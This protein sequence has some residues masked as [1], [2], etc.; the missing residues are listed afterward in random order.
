MNQLTHPMLV[1]RANRRRLGAASVT[2]LIASLAG[3]LLVGSAGPAQAAAVAVPLG[4]AHTFV[5]LAG[6]GTTNTGVTRLGG[7]IGTSPTPAMTGM[8]TAPADADRVVFT[9][10]GVNHA[11][12]GA[13][14]GAKGALLTAY[15]N[16]KQ[17]ASDQTISA[18]LG[19]Q[20]LTRGVYT[21]GSTMGLTGPLTLDAEGD[22]DAVF[23]FQVGSSLTTATSSSVVLVGEAQA[24]NVFWQVEEDASLGTT[25]SF[26]GTLMAENSITLGTG[27]TVRGRVLASNGSV[28]MDTNTITRPECDTTPPDDD[29]DDTPPDEDTP[30]EETPDEDTPDGDTPD[31]DTPDDDE[32]GG[33]TPDDGTD[34]PTDDQT[35]PLVPTPVVDTPQIT[36]TPRGSVDTGSRGSTR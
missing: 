26:V 35:P 5:V 32:P 1:S 21:S 30:D 34:T 13:T 12:D 36:Q 27:A 3:G 9:G 33:D 11:G 24:C 15:G 18:D 2:G 16:A 6:A 7:D 10:G 8:G 14:Q 28:T 25:S 29:E 31:G 23:V 22:S 17:Q 19:G 20:R 4:S